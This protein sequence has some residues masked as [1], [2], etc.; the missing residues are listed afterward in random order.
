MP[1]S[2]I[3]RI[4]QETQH[5]ANCT[6]ACILLVSNHMPCFSL[7]SSH[8]SVITPQFGSFLHCGFQ[9]SPS[10][11]GLTRHMYKCMSPLALA[12]QFRIAMS[13]PDSLYHAK[14]GFDL[15]GNFLLRFESSR[16]NLKREYPAAYRVG[17]LETTDWT[18]GNSISVVLWISCPPKGKSTCYQS[19][20]G[21]DRHVQGYRM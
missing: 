13:V 7:V 14:P 16:L 10:I 9:H 8:Y 20:T 1:Q 19:W 18:L 6:C 12:L 17:G 11:C 3:T 4:N 15:S 5:E 2:P 21:T